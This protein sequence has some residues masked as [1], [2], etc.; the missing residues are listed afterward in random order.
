MLLHPTSQP[1]FS[2]YSSPLYLECS[3]VRGRGNKY[4]CHFLKASGQ[5]VEAGDNV[6]DKWLQW[7]RD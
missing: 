5:L 6:P 2:Q 7:Q 3:V 4:Y 1:H